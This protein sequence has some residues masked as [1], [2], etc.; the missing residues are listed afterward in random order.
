MHGQQ[1]L[2]AQLL[3]QKS[4]QTIGV[5]ADAGFA[6]NPTADAIAIMANACNVLVR[7]FIRP[8]SGKW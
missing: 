4:V 5:A 3:V 1:L 8:P 7:V 2:S 6:V